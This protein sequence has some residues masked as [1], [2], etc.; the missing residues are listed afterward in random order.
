MSD[1][2]SHP[3]VSIDS[4][5]V[6]EPTQKHTYTLILLHGLGSSGEKFGRELLD[7]GFTSLGHN[8]TA[9][10]PGARFVFPT[11]KR[12]RSSAFNCA[13]LTQW[14]DI[15]RI[16]DPSFQNDRQL[17]GLEESTKQILK[18]MHNELNF[19]SPSNLILGGLSQGCAMSVAILL[20]LD[21]PIGGFIGMSGFLT[22]QADLEDALIP[23]EDL[24]D[25]PFIRDDNSISAIKKHPSVAAQRLQRDLLC[26]DLLSEPSVEKTSYKTPVF[27]GHGGLDEKVPVALGKA[28]VKVLREAQYQVA[29][30][31]YQDEGH[32][33]KIPDEI[34]D[35][36]DFIKSEVG[37]RVTNGTIN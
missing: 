8:L 30:R 3:I 32:W 18:I 37:W 2:S 1:S 23:K 6:V 24:E 25:D 7:T 16:H 22:F 27:L 20:S 5:Y 34:D 17:R 15:T 21:Y 12:R 26:L 33:Y 11:S 19:V 13:T 36:V 14:F 31:C 10:L 9:L 35:I 28:I 4:L 29:W